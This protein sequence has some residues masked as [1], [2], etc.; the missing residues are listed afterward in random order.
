MIIFGD[1][2]HYFI[3][4]LSIGA[5]FT[6]SILSGI[7]ISVAVFCEELPHEL[8]EFAILLNAGMTL[9]QAVLYNFLSACTCYIG[10][11]FG[12]LLGDFTHGTPH[13][14]ALVGG[15]F[16]YISLVD[17]MGEM[18]E[19]TKNVKNDGLKFFTL[20]NIS[21]IVGVVAVFLMAMYSEIIS[22][23]TME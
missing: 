5:A 20:Q 8:G 2:L 6:N 16:L 18:N 13:T 9:R 3:D 17:I 21:I 10:L 15:M 23:E 12:I 7:S 4:G 19:A 1:G 11:V 22:F 14:F